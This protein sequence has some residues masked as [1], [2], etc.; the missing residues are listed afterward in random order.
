MIEELEPHPDLIGYYTITHNFKSDLTVD[1]FTNAGENYNILSD[2]N[3]NIFLL[4]KLDELNLL[5]ES[6]HICDCGIGL[7]NTLFEIYLQ[8]KELDKI[9]SF[10]GIEKQKVYIDFINKE[11]LHLW[12]DGLNL[13]QDDIMNLDYS[14]YNIVY[15]YSPFNNQKQL[16][17]MYQ[18]IIS[19]IKS[20]SI[21]I[22][23]ANKGLGHFN[24]LEEFVELEKIKLDN[25]FVFKK[26]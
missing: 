19:D 21:L 23:H 7:G 13:I 16:K 20:N 11:L 22:E 25:I 14:N 3:E 8:S 2:I 5:K 18:K 15:S 26:K 17:S 9:F 12:K 1:I 24:L 4:K 10:T 6:N